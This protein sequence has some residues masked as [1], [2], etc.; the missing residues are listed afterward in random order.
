M[1]YKRTRLNAREAICLGRS[2]GL[3]SLRGAAP[4]R[5]AQSL[6]KPRPPSA[7]GWPTDREALPPASARPTQRAQAAP[8]SGRGGHPAPGAFGALGRVRQRAGQPGAMAV[9]VRARGALWGLAALR[10]QGASRAAMVSAAGAGERACGGEGAAARA[11]PRLPR[12][13]SA[14]RRAHARPRPGPGLAE[15]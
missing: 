11:T 12:V 9:V 5:A 7:E 1:A 4:V 6:Q 15:A 13:T 10:G 2:P 8:S 3:G 14:E